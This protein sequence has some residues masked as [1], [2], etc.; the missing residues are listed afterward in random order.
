ALAPRP[1]STAR[2]GGCKPAPG[3]VLSRAHMKFIWALPASLPGL[4]FARQDHHRTHRTGRSTCTRMA[5][6]EREDWNRRHGE[7]GPLFG[8]EPNRF[9]VAEVESLDPGRALYVACGA[10]RNAVWLPER[11][12]TVTGID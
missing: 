4:V 9:L 11:G 7:A 8:V 3:G 10:G 6:M 1:A 12:W 5:N 2:P